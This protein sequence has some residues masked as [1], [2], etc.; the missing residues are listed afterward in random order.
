MSIHSCNDL[1]ELD[2]RFHDIQKYEG[3]GELWA[4]IG[5]AS[6]EE[7]KNYIYKRVSREM[8]LLKLLN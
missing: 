2:E 1:C 3:G 7:M 5:G 8:E 4:E 6:K